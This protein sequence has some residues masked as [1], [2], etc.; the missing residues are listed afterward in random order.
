MD[1]PLD[2][3]GELAPA[4]VVTPVTLLREQA[5]KLGAKTRHVI[6][7]RVDTKTANKTFVHSLVL[8]VPSLDDY[9]YELLKVRHGIAL[10]PVSDANSLKEFP[11]EESF[12]EWLR[13]ELSSPPTKRIIGNLMAQANS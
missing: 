1:D 10:Y 4:D 3:W 2:F 8:Q 6:E 13:Q 12:V 5:S 11:D 7:A 9:E